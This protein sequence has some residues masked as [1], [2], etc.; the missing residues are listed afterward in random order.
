MMSPNKWEIW[1]AK[2]KFED[3]PTQVKPRPVLVIDSK[4]C[5][6]ISIKITSHH[7]KSDSIVFIAIFCILA[8]DLMRLAISWLTY[9]N[10]HTPFVQNIKS[11]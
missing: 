8:R 5:Y 11:L 2:V 10:N 4:R 9:I 7:S 1:L 6:I 3:N